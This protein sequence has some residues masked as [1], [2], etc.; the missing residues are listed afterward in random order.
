MTRRLM[1]SGA[2]AAM[3]CAVC[4][5]SYLDDPSSPYGIDA[6]RRAGSDAVQA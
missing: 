2:P 4:R 3:L 1:R 6:E 5:P